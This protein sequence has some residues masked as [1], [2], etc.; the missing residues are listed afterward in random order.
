MGGE[1]MIVDCVSDLHG[2]YPKLDGGHLL[3]VAG[4]W[5]EN[6]SGESFYEFLNWLE[7][8]KYNRIVVIA[9]NHDNIAVHKLTETT[10]PVRV[11]YFIDGIKNCTY[12]CD[13]GTEFEIDERVHF[14][15]GD[16]ADR[17]VYKRKIKIWGSPWTTRF[18]GMNPKCMAFTV[19]T[20]KELA[21]KWAMIPEDVDILV[22]H[23]PP[24]GML[25]KT[26]RGEEV[27]SQ[28]LTN[29]IH[30]MQPIVHVFG[31][32]HESYGKEN[33]FIPA[34]KYI[35]IADCMF[36]NASHVNEHYEP[37]NKPIRIEL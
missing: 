20:D 29:K 35:G 21:E 11:S 1:K 10:S 34:S 7:C 4:D 14:P 8:Q 2:H 17:F 37:V 30:K 27:G 9:G 13:S 6:D 23:C 31:H 32:I 5:C 19:D 15:V 22:T 26:A 16:G 18:P 25:D 36:I 3:I 33:C 28:S 12:L 24:K